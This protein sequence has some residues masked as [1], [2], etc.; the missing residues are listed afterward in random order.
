MTAS[1]S[2]LDRPAARLVALAI[3]LGSLGAL[4]AI[5]WKDIAG[6]GQ[7]ARSSDDPFVNCFAQRRGD[8]D[9]MLRDG[10]VD[11]QRAALFM[12]RAEALCRAQTKK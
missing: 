1:G 4:A 3:C 11:A 6:S 12:A 8:I 10:V 7:A 2:F 5:H 9:N